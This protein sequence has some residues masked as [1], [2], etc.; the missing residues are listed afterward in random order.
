MNPNAVPRRAR[1]TIA[2]TEISSKQ[3]GVEQ[4]LNDLQ[5]DVAGI[6]KQAGHQIKA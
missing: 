4:S 2:L 6:L 3:K 5:A 1:V